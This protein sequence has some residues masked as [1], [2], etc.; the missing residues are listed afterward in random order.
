[1]FCIGCKMSILMPFRFSTIVCLILLNLYQIWHLSIIYLFESI[2][3]T[4]RS[5]YIS[6]SSLSLSP[7]LLVYLIRVCLPEDHQIWWTS[8]NLITRDML[9]NAELYAEGALCVSFVE[10]LGNVIQQPTGTGDQREGRVDI[11]FGGTRAYSDLHFFC[12]RDIRW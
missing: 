3:K 12:C 1:M 2:Q 6:P 8:Q 7:A 11:Q 9:L 4:G 5:I 10:V